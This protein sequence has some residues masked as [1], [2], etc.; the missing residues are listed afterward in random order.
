M[1]SDRRE[2]ERFGLNLDVT[3]EGGGSRCNGTV[4]DISSTGCFVLGSGD[5]EDGDQV[6]V[7]I[8]L[9]TGGTLSLWGE[10]VN[11]VQEIGF[12]IRFVALTDSQ[13]TFLDRLTDTLRN[14]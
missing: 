6:R 9:N 4:S 5:V 14:D 11:H 12:G 13:K 1:S 7:D 8:P 3:W 2:N 10:V